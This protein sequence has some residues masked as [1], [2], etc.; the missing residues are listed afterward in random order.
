MNSQKRNRLRIAVI[1]LAAGASVDS[2]V[3]QESAAPDSK[4]SESKAVQLEEITVTARKFAERLVDAPLAVTAFTARELEEA[5]VRDI[6][7][8]ARRT[9]GFAMQD[10]GRLTDQPFVRGASVNSVFRADQHTS[11][12]IDGVFVQGLAR[13]LDFSNDI[14]RVEIIRGPQSALF[15]R[16]TFAGAI[17]YVT[18]GP[19]PD[20]EGRA[21]AS[22]GQNGLRDASLAVSGPIQRD[23]LEFRLSGQF[24]DYGGQWRNGLDGAP[25]GVERTRGGALALRFKPAD[26]IDITLRSSLV[27]FNDGHSAVAIVGS[28]V[29][30]CSL[31]GT[32]RY[33]CGDVPVPSSVSLNLA[34]VGGGYRR[35]DQQRNYLRAVWTRD[36][37]EVS[38]TT[39][40]NDERFDYYIDGDGTPLRSSGGAFHSHFTE[41]LR[42]TSQDLRLTWNGAGALRGLVGVYW[43]DGYYA[44]PQLAPSV[45]AANPRISVN[46]SVYA[47]LSW[48]FAPTMTLSLDG[49]YQ[50]DRITVRNPAGVRT[51]DQTSKNFLPRAIL[52][53][54]P[55]ED[56]TFY[57]SASKGSRPASFNTVSGTPP[58]FIN[59]KEQELWSYE[60]G[61][62]MRLLD[63]RVSLAAALYQ[64]NWDNQTTQQQLVVT[65][66]GQ[67]TPRPIIV[68]ANVG[69]TRIQ[70]FEFEGSWLAT[71]QLELY[72]S[73][74]YTDAEYLNFLSDVCLNLTG[75]RLCPR[76]EKL[77]NTPPRTASLGAAWRQPVGNGLRWIT[78]ADFIKRGRMPM[79]EINTATNPPMENLNLRTGLEA[80]A[81]TVTLWVNNV[82]DDDAPSFATRFSD[83]NAIPQYGYQLTLRRGREAGVTA[84]YR[85]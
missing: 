8:L 37:F 79:A 35:T 6:V 29:N 49:R 26:G 81:W 16:A 38:S 2:T 10:A 40:Y 3:A 80:E 20:F 5:G 47:S 41:T 73:Y 39:S 67:T 19:T 63:G 24:H 51:N 59:V 32:R 58:E 25:I 61:S 45:V 62:R 68:N 4:N 84:S 22:I 27:K 66:P 57:L 76:G 31:G 70:G 64:V 69:K 71:D 83:L 82:T 30:N 54:K 33:L 9:P 75:N 44:I 28:A 78:R 43:F 50:D 1:A 13:T 42:D 11:S 14:E 85:F 46:K 60:L 53:W 74:A 48:A 15:G 36:A 7:D 55:S 65:P 72:A 18:K 56:R 12:F 21:V 52:D 77:Q 17:N 34:D 23:V